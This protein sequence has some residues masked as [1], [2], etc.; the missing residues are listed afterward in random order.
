VVPVDNT[1]TTTTSIGAERVKPQHR[2]I[3]VITII[4]SVLVVIFQPVPLGYVLPFVPKQNLWK[5]ISGTRFLQ[6]GRHAG[7]PTL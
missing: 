1:I 7:H 5:W 4:T 2:Q 3:F 6:A